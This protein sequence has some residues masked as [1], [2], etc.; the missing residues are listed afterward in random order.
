[1]HMHYFHYHC[2]LYQHLHQCTITNTHHH[3]YSTFII[4][5][6][7]APPQLY[8]SLPLHHHHDHHYTISHI[9]KKDLYHTTPTKNCCQKNISLFKDFTTH[10]Q[11]LSIYFDLVLKINF[12]IFT[13]YDVTSL[14]QYLHN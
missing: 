14:L 12:F 5:I 4:T 3:H 10:L 1:M 11:D 8:H 13:R 9:K 6:P 2:H 7:L